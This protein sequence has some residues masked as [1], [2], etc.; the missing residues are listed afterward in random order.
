GVEHLAYAVTEP[1]RDVFDVLAGVIT[2]VVKALR[3]D[4]N[5]RW[6]DPELSYSRPIRWLLALWGDHNVPVEISQLRS[7]RTT[8]T[9]RGDA[10][11]L[12]Q[13]DSADVLAPILAQRG[14]V[15]STE[16]RL[17]QIRS[18]AGELAASVGAAVDLDGEADLVGEIAGLVE[19]PH[20][21]LGNFD[22][23]YLRL[24]EDIL[25]TV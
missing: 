22:P 11:P 1:G 9:L 12:V 21:I 4:K 10:E 13:I 24:P 25:T 16:E 14:I 2:G 3:A 23:D 7:G 20:G 18:G 19:A 6:A 17:A 5:M 8:Y 15:L